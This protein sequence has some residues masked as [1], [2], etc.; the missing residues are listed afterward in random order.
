VFGEYSELRIAK[1][2]M[3]SQEVDYNCHIGDQRFPKSHFV[4][5]FPLLL[6]RG[7]IIA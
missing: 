6:Q 2:I 7:L 5:N 3:E 4:N 1:Q